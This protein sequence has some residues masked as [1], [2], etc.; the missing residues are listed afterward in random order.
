[1]QLL[2]MDSSV[3]RM[4]RFLRE[5]QHSATH[6]FAKFPTAAEAAALETYIIRHADSLSAPDLWSQLASKNRSKHFGND[7]VYNF[8][9]K[10]FTDRP[11]SRGVSRAPSLLSSIK[12]LAMPPTR[13]AAEGRCSQS[14]DDITQ[15]RPL[16]PPETKQLLDS[17]DFF[18]DAVTNKSP[19]RDCPNPLASVVQSAVE[20]LGIF[21]ESPDSTTA[22]LLYTKSI[23]AGY[24]MDGYHCCNHAADVTNRLVALLHLTGIASASKSSHRHRQSMLAAVVCAGNVQ[25]SQVSNTAFLHC[26]PWSPFCITEETTIQ[27]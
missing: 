24:L 8:L 17:A 20:S 22:L 5:Y 13:A 11:K 14:F 23:E 1:M 3:A 10:E 19:L 9:L 15:W 18:L 25:T 27:C 6:P 7:G 2:D 21:P 16:C 26:T 12:S 4:L